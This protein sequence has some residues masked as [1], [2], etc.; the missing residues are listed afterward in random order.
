MFSRSESLH[1]SWFGLKFGIKILFSR[2]NLDCDYAG[3]N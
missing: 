3:E 2:Q 1:N